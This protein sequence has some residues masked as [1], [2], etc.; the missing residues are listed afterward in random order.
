MKKSYD[1]VDF[2]NTPWTI[3]DIVGVFF[4]LLIVSIG[5]LIFYILIV[6][7]QRIQ[8]LLF[9]Y[10]ASILSF[11]IPF[12]WLKK[13]YNIDL[14][15]LGMKKGKYHFLNQLLIATVI[16]SIMFGVAETLVPSIKK[17][18]FINKEFKTESFFA[19][20]LVPFTLKG[21][22]RFILNPIGEELLFRGFL[23]GY[24]RKKLNIKFAIIFQAIISTAWHLVYIKEAF[25]SPSL[26]IQV[27][28]IALIF[29]VMAGIY[30]ATKS[31]YPCIICHG[32]YNFLLLVYPIYT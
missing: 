14:G 6:R 18:E 24:L 30:E 29:V 4:I 11:C 15:S 12:F 9:S 3:I 17:V 27:G 7:D 21:F 25:A 26:F 8:F 2:Y 22:A 28:Y 5:S 13:K 19:L 32:M 10:T 1:E 23:Y 20:F 16:A 31:L